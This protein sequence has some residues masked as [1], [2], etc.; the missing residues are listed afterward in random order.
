MSQQGP[1]T[2]KRKFFIVPIL[3]AIVYKVIP[4]LMRFFVASKN[5]VG[6]MQCKST[7]TKKKQVCILK[8]GPVI[9]E[10]SDIERIQNFVQRFFKKKY[11]N[12]YMEKE[13][14]SYHLK[15]LRIVLFYIST[16]QSN[17]LGR[18]IFERQYNTQCI[19]SFKCQIL[20]VVYSRSLLSTC[21]L[22]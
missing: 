21:K 6:T 1:P 7:Y 5:Q 9:I 3:Q 18:Y 22:K 4:H 16:I 15:N 14:L 12:V 10:Q 11:L 20:V 8:K 17:Q 2:L 19:F 13:V